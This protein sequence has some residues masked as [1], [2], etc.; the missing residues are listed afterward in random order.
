MPLINCEVIIFLTW[1]EKC[2]IV[3]G[4]YGDREPKFAITDAKLYVS[5][6]TLSLQD[7]EN[8][9]SN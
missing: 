1:F 8:Y 9:C 3:T 7:N 2:I 4:N 6:V 5:V